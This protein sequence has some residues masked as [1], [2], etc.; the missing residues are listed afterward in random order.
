MQL[1]L[2]RTRPET[3]K[4]VGTR[5]LGWVADLYCRVIYYSF[6]YGSTN[7]NQGPEISVL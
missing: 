6:E 4:Y 2:T 1:T 7:Q 5:G 3:R